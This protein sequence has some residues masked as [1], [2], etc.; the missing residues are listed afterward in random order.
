MQPTNKHGILWIIFSLLI[1]SLI[2]SAHSVGIPISIRRPSDMDVGIIVR[3]PLGT[4]LERTCGDDPSFW[5]STSIFNTDT[6]RNQ[7]V[8]RCGRLWQVRIRGSSTDPHRSLASDWSRSRSRPIRDQRSGS[9]PA[10]SH[11]LIAQAEL[12]TFTLQTDTDRKDNCIYFGVA[13][14]IPIK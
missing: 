7:I 4:R 6:P 14:I 12:P 2:F 1:L 11:T 8:T 9:S 3:D 13:Y 10:A 5:E